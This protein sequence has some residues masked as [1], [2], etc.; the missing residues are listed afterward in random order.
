[1][2]SIMQSSRGKIRWFY[3]GADPGNRSFI[4]YTLQQKISNEQ[5]SKARYDNLDRKDPSNCP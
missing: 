2:I 5:S 4:P 3:N 1:M